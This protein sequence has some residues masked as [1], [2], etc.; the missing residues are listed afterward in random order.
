MK[1]I[2][3]IGP[4]RAG[5]SSLANLLSDK[6]NYQILRVDT[7]RKAFDNVFPELNIS[8]KTAINHEPFK[9]FIQDFFKNSINYSRNKYPF[10]I[11]SCDITIEDYQKYFQNENTL[12][13]ILG[14]SDI[15][16]KE[17][18]KNIRFYD[19]NTD[20]SAK[21]SDEYMLE[22]CE[23]YIEYS[24]KNKI[25]CEQY[26]LNYYETSHNREKVL[27]KILKSMEEDR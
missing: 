27:H 23:R 20:W 7:L 4:P 13:Y 1:N 14:L 19:S 16:A 9:K 18:L 11:E 3:I 17:L 22:L 15:N 10:I 21:Y 26:H 8:S 2:I 12:L 24:K 25:L 5:K 6:Y